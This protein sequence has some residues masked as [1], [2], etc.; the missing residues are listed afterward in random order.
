MSTFTSASGKL[1]VTVTGVTS[2]QIDH[3]PLLLANTEYTVVLP[4]NIKKFLLKGQNK[5]N[6]KVRYA[7]GADPLT[8]PYGVYYSEG[9][10]DV[11]TVT[12]YI[13]STTASQVVELVTWS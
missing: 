8:V 11:V 7:S 6:L 3:V 2:P 4:S 10:I 13:E 5:G 1:V 9:D 12:V